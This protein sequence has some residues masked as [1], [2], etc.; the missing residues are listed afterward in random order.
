MPD[1]Q[2]QE[3]EWDSSKH[4]DFDICNLLRV[5]RKIWR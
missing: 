4:W 1:R 2:I 5:T 3:C